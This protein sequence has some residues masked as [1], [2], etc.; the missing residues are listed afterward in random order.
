MSPT[1]RTETSGTCRKEMA[2]LREM[3]MP[4]ICLCRSLLQRS[5]QIGLATRE[6]SPTKGI[7]RHKTQQIE[8]PPSNMCVKSWQETVRRQDAETGV[9]QAESGI[10]RLRASEREQSQIPRKGWH[11]F[12]ERALMEAWGFATGMLFGAKCRDED[13][14]ANQSLCQA[15]SW[16]AHRLALGPPSHYRVTWPLALCSVESSMD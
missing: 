15:T 11:P 13:T 12:R 4:Y 2:A 8:G 14:T 6:G 9:P 5:E 7:C 3:G 16:I 1:T 10:Q